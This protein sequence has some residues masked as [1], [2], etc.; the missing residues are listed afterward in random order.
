MRSLFNALLGMVLCGQLASASAYAA[1]SSLDESSKPSVVVFAAANALPSCLERGR[2]CMTAG[3][4]TLKVPTTLL[5][6]NFSGSGKEAGIQTSDVPAFR[7]ILQL[8]DAYRVDFDAEAWT[9]QVS[10]LFRK[11]ALAGNAMFILTDVADPEQTAASHIMTAL[12]QAAI[13]AGESVS[14]SLSLSPSDG[15]RA[16]HTYKLRVVQIVNGKEV[17]LADGHVHLM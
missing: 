6:G 4:S 3:E 8:D 17:E 15:F 7:R 11:H 9:L 1:A 2:L 14:M 5:A 13:P 12:Y 16:G 10:A